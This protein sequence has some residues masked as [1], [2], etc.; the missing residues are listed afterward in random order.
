[1]KCHSPSNS[2]HIHGHNQGISG[3]TK[4][5]YFCIRSK[6]FYVVLLLVWLAYFYY[7]YSNNHPRRHPFKT[8]FPAHVLSASYL[9][10]SRSNVSSAGGK[11]LEASSSSI[12]AETDANTSRDDDVVDLI[13]VPGHA[14]IKLNMIAQA[15]REDSA[16]YLLDYQ[17]NQGFPSIISSHIKVAIDLL[18]N[19][20]HSLLIFSGGE[21]RKDVG[22][23]SEAASYYYFAVEKHWLTAD[24]LDGNRVFLEEFALDS[25]E[26]VLYSICRFREIKGYYPSRVF[27]VG[28]DFKSRRFEQLHRMAIGFSPERFHYVKVRPPSSSQQQQQQHGFDRVRSMEGERLAYQQFEGDLYGCSDPALAQK[29]QARNPFHRTIPYL[30]ACPEVVSLLQ[31]CGPGLYADMDQLPWNK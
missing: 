3:I 7:I 8:K 21:T 16:W 30:S 10:R 6:L 17:R 5:T 15:D 13:V 29:R 22:P 18:R 14:V 25:Y 4:C 2:N 12:A 11:S 31:W 19:N 27:I 9:S 28:F 1:M 24:L 26:N 23:M 20:S